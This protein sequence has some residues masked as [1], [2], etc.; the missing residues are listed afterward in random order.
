MKSCCGIPLGYVLGDEQKL[1]IDPLT[2]PLVQEIFARYA[3]GETV[4]AIVESLNE[5]GLQSKRNKPFSMGSFNALLRNRKY[6]GEYQY[7]DVVIPGGVPA[8]ISE[9]LFNRVQARMEKNKRTPAS[10]KAAEEYLL[11][12]K[13][14]CG[15]CERMMV[16]ESGTS[17]TGATH[18]YYKCGN[19]KRRKGCK[20]KAVKK[21]WI[22]RAAVVLTVNRVLQDA[23]IDKISDKLIALQD[24]EDIALPA[25]RQQLEETEKAIDNLLT[26]IQ[27]G[28]ITKSTKKRMDDGDV[29]SKVYQKQM[30]DIFINSIYAFDDRLVFTYNF[31]GGTQTVSLADIE[32]AFGSDLVSMRHHTIPPE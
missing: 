7:Q 2:A 15:D 24:R 19:A 26:A 10:A 27:Q 29:N 23:E 22:E 1:V 4:R 9:E 8:I 5:R 17:R 18:Y 20:R 28:I 14:F 32:V 21:N 3:E 6:I 16:G 12:T 30:I 13:L 31:Q 11:T 25:L